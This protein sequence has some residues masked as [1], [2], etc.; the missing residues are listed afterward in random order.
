MDLMA[1]IGATN[2]RCA[3]LNDKGQELASEVFQNADFSGVAAVLSA[4]ALRPSPS[5]RRKE[6]DAAPDQDAA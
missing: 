2:T 1:D 3:L 6:E 4:S 5:H